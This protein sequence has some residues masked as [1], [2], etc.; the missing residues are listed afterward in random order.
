LDSTKDQVEQLEDIQNTKPHDRLEAVIAE[1]SPL[2]AKL[3]KI[4]EQNIH[5]RKL[6]EI[7]ESFMAH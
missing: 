1:L 4:Y 6:V 5:V 2:E 7:A 3:N